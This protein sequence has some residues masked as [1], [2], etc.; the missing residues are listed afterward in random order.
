MFSIQRGVSFFLF[1]LENQVFF[2]HESSKTCKDIT[3]TNTDV[4]E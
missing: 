3:F 4:D 2:G 1:S